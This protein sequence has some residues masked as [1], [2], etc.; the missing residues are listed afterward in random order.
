MK[1]LDKKN[2][3]MFVV[4]GLSFIVGL[5]FLIVPFIS[6]MPDGLE[7]VS[8]DTVGFLKKDDFKS[9]TKA[10]IP[11]YIVPGLKNKFN[12]KRYAGIIGVCIVFGI[13]V[14][15]GYL[16]KKRRKNL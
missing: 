5:V 11:D 15:A 10:P 9:P 12:A 13:T 8:E 1:L 16:L 2:R 3:V 6:D 14:F 7:K 4:F